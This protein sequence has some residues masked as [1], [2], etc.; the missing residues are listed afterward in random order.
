MWYTVPDTTSPGIP[1]KLV[2]TYGVECDVL[3][4]PPHLQAARGARARQSD[5]PAG[6]A[7]RHQL[8]GATHRTAREHT[9]RFTSNQNYSVLIPIID[10]INNHKIF[11]HQT[12]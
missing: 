10:I 6:G 5:D 11:S 7:P 3:I 4:V 8:R 1:L 2:P 12:I 9:Q